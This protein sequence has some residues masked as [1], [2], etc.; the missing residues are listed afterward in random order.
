MSKIE[1][2]LK[3]NRKINRWI[4]MCWLEEN[5][6]IFINLILIGRLYK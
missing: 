1:G 6:R 5:I 2:D 3:Y 4:R